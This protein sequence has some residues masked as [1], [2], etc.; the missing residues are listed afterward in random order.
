MK[1]AN[2]FLEECSR[3]DTL[4]R[5]YKY[6]TVRKIRRGSRKTERTSGR[7]ASLFDTPSDGR[8]L[9]F[10]V[11]LTSSREVPKPYTIL[12]ENIGLRSKSTAAAPRLHGVE[13][14]DTVKKS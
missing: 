1:L 5:V 11:L 10:F 6:N 7:A 12:G 2:G 9:L 8:S 3:I 14:T 4:F 13:G